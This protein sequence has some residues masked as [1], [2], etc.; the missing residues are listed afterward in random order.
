MAEPAAQWSDEQ[1]QIDDGDVDLELDCPSC[2]C[3][4]GGAESYEVFRVCPTCRRHFWLAGRERLDLLL[5]PGSF[6]ETN[7]ALASVDP[8]VFRDP[9]PLPDR[10]AEERERSGISEAVITGVGTIG[11][12]SAV[13]IVLDF[14]FLGG[15]LGIV[16]GEKVTLAMELAATR[17]LPLVAICS[18]GSTRA[19]EGILSLVQLAKTAGAAARLHRSGVPFI[20]VLTH[21]TTG[22]VYAGLA[23]QADIV[24]AEPGAQAGLTAIREPGRAATA[25]SGTNS[26]E[27]LRNHGL[28]DDVVDRT[29]QRDL[30]GALLELFANRGSV[31]PVAPPPP[32]PP[33]NLRAFEEL[34]LA[35]HAERPT[36]FDYVDQLMTTFVELHG[37]RVAADDPAVICGFG[38][39]D[40][41]TVA[42]IA[43]ERGRGEYRE[44]RRGG[45]MAAA[46]YRKAVRLMRLAGHLEIPLITFVD[47]PGPMIGAEA[48][49]D[50]IGVALAQALGLMSILPV[51]IVSAIVGEA[52]SAGALALGVG[53]R[54]VMQ[55]HAVVSVFGPESALYR[56]ADRAV[57]AAA[58][59]KV[60]ARDCMRLGIVDRIVPEPTP[61]AH[62][63]P[64][65]AAVFLRSAIAQA[66]SELS[67]AAP[68]R[69][70]DDRAQRVRHFG[71]ATPE[72]RE[73]A[74]REL[75]EWQEL[76]RTIGRSL[77]ELRERI[78]GRQLTL[79]SLSQRPHL[80]N[81][82]H[83]RRLNVHRADIEAFA[84][85]LAATGRGIVRGQVAEARGQGAGPAED[86]VQPPKDVEP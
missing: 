72:G 66:L 45:R 41:V 23:N 44:R 33:S 10:L 51:P 30:L 38:R 16:A 85:R 7:A 12:R 34:L 57:D 17:R 60:T 11:G 14:A 27:V 74:R 21:P 36:S 84:G 52:G 78:E 63:D 22:G 61:G 29:R 73:A 59:L 80:P 77:G 37:D 58:S 4:L 1:G 46:G 62:A 5:D 64:G 69:L 9:L 68:R 55:E 83:L 47:S 32:P 6:A 3:I 8:L 54:I 35:R 76:Q 50:G 2:G 39:L 15:S 65:Q 24:F 49:T 67:G 53:D 18:G 43:Q 82:P 86:P 81:L 20:S 48:E 75:R 42:V 25:G 79:S 28:V 13:L 40:G 56:E 70:L 71:Q 19:Q 31:S 26:A